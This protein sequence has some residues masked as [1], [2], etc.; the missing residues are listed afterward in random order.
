MCI[1]CRGGPD[2]KGVLDR[3]FAR[4]SGY[5]QPARSRSLRSSGGN[6]DV[7]RCQPV[8]K[9]EDID[10]ADRSRLPRDVVLARMLGDLEERRWEVGKKQ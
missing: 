8:A 1:V 7:R 9:L 2:Q 3:Y 5:K 10:K 6:T 4:T